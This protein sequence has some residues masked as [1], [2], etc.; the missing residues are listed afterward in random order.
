MES[1]VNGRGILSAIFAPILSLFCDFFDKDAKILAFRQKA[2]Y[3]IR[4][5]HI[6]PLQ[7]RRFDTAPKE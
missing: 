3:N 4:K 7:E 2:Y 6:R 5:Q 1:T